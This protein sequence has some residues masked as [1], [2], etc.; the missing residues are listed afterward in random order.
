LILQRASGKL[1]CNQFLNGVIFA[2]FQNALTGQA[3]V[4]GSFAY[5]AFGQAVFLAS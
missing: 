4:E 2:R 5:A 1:L 3:V